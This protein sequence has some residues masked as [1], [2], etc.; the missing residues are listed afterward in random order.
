[1]INYK[2]LFNNVVCKIEL[3]SDTTKSGIIK[4]DTLTKEETMDVTKLVVLAVG[5]DVK[6][7]KVGDIVTASPF[8][9]HQFTPISLDGE[10]HMVFPENCIVGIHVPVIK[11]STSKPL[12]TA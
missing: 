4:G 6:E 9:R 12:A 1:M 8:V 5:K 10:Q 11:V 3:V 7:V 2:P